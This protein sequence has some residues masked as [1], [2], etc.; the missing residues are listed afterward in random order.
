LGIYGEIYATLSMNVQF[1]NHLFFLLVFQ[2]WDFG[3]RLS[4]K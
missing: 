1:L 4:F 2:L 3:K